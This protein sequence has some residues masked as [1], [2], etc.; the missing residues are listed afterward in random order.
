MED[1][2]CQRFQPASGGNWQ[3]LRREKYEHPYCPTRITSH[4]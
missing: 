1:R 2:R 3:T 4:S